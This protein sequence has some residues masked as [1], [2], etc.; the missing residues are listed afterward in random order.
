MAGLKIHID[1]SA[2]Q[3]ASAQLRKELKTLGQEALLG[4]KDFKKLE[5]RLDKGMKAD[6]AEKTLDHLK[7]TI[8]LTRLETA[9]FQAG[10]GDYSGA[11]KTMAFGADGAKK[12]LL[13]LKSAIGGLLVGGAVS[14]GVSKSLTQFKNFETAVVDMGK[15]TKRSQEELRAEVMA[16]DPVVGSATDLMKGYYQTISA[17]VTDPIKSLEFLTQAA[18]TSKA[19]HVEQGEVVKALSKVMAG[20][21]DEIK[22]VAEASDLLFTIEKEGQTSVAELVPIIGDLA[23]ISHEVGVSQNEMAGSLALI[24]QTSGS[25]AEAATKYK[26]ILMGLYKPQSKMKELLDSLGYSSG[27]AMVKELGLVDALK[28]VKSESE[29]S[30]IAISEL[31]ESSEALVGIAALGADEF[32]TM[33]EKIAAMG[34]GA[35]STDEAFKQWQ[36]T[37]AATEEVFYNTIGKFAI[38]FGE[39][40]APS[41][42]RGMEEF[43]QTLEDNK[44]GM[45]EAFKGVGVAAESTISMVGGISAR[46]ANLGAGLGLAEAGVVSWMDIATATPAEMAEIVRSFD[47]TN[48]ATQKTTFSIGEATDGWEEYAKS[49]SNAALANAEISPGV[50]LARPKAV[51]PRTPAPIDSQAELGELGG[52][53]TDV[54]DFILGIDEAEETVMHAWRRLD[55]AGIATADE[56]IEKR[57]EQY[58]TDAAAIK[59]GKDADIQAA[60]DRENAYATMYRGIGRSTEKQY[61]F[62]KDLLEK[63]RDNYATLT[64]DKITA[65][66]WFT[67]EHE[68]LLR[69]QALASDDLY[70]GTEDGL[71]RIEDAQKS[72]A[73]VMSDTTVDTYSQMGDN[74]SEFLNPLKDGFLELEDLYKGVLDSMLQSTVDKVADMAAAWVVD[75]GLSLA[76]G[77]LSAA[78]G[79]VGGAAVD[80]LVDSF[81]FWDTGAWMVKKNQIAQLHEGEMVV[82]AD[83]AEDLRKQMTGEGDYEGLADEAPGG[84]WESVSDVTDS[85]VGRAV[86]TGMAMRAAQAAAMDPSTAASAAF[87]GPAIGMNIVSSAIEDRMGITGGWSFGGKVVGAT[88]GSQFG[89]AAAALGKLAGSLIGDMIGDMT[90][91]RENEALRD[92][93]EESQGYFGG[94][95][96]FEGLQ[97][98]GT[99]DI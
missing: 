99:S 46:M 58:E 71:K 38:E 44:S 67:V 90:N 23:A 48:E 51:A 12:S 87:S 9:K 32:G 2:S 36:T 6:K 31:F 93:L 33:T 34:E 16:M 96:A 45:I 11:F 95:Q 19:S 50:L 56:V 80:W 18:E 88:L 35:G 83:Q 89:P 41:M 86:A 76:G 5:D 68:K 43:A 72:W 28:R 30:G 66:K 29:S 22:S 77:A 98:A 37:F 40:M 55:R 13:G 94:R 24:T 57:K 70:A 8:G 84:G 49:V 53:F 26:S 62:E 27:V 14:A 85:V 4:E 81:G 64:K 63:Q 1:T 7:K 82:P 15:V 65:D 52:G 74:F 69:K 10:I 75:T 39:E 42:K 25:T 91:T 17:G 21:G 61:E 73:Q 3:R 92:H 97:G 60:R 47:E 20:Y 79:A 78:G 59:E 54:A